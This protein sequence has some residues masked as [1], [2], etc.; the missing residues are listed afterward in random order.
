M[1]TVKDDLLR[2]GV[3]SLADV[4]R[5]IGRGN[6][7]VKRWITGD[8]PLYEATNPV[9][10]DFYDLISLWV[11]SRL[12][13]EGVPQLAIRTGREYLS[14]K[15]ITPYPFVHHTGIATLGKSFF[16]RVDEWWVDVGRSGQSAFQHMIEQK[17]TPVGNVSDELRQI[18]EQ[19]LKPME[20][21]DNDIV[22]AW[23][24][25]P[26]VKVDPRVQSG[27]PCLEGT[28]VPALMIASLVE[29]SGGKRWHKMIAENY[30]LQV[31]QVKAAVDYGT[32]VSNRSF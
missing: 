11:I 7:T 4:A 31:D 5:L 9:V 12:R 10:L 2:L 17:L 32:L 20:F 26:G 15:L 14:S 19:E 25:H 13:K 8:Q 6:G 27:Q 18:Y 29:K 16:G 22:N 30:R 24:P 1:T 28:R 21:D 23:I 3:Y